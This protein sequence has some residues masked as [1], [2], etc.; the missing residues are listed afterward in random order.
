MFVILFNID[1]VNAG[2]FNKALV[3]PVQFVH[4]LVLKHAS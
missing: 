1:I 2:R 3:S 4:P